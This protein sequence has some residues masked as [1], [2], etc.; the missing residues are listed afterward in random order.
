MS[1]VF[2]ARELALGRDVVV[3]V[4]PPDMAAGVSVDRFRREIQLAAQLQHPHIVPVLTPGASETLPVLHD[5][6]RRRRVASAPA[7]ARGPFADERSARFCATSS[8]RWRTRTTRRRASR[9]QAGERSAVE[10]TRVVRLRYRARGRSRDRRRRT[11]DRDRP[12]ARHTGVHVARQAAG[13]R[14]VDQRTDVGSLPSLMY[15]M[16][17]GT[18]PF[19]ALS[20]REL[21][22]AHLTKEPAPLVPAI[23]LSARSDLTGDAVSRER[24]GTATAVRS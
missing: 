13:D 14:N 21:A 9:H 6:V 1:R 3:K 20:M 10:R 2:V 24:S 19:T 7:R 23:Q 16:L 15:E 4:L 8:M 22:V 18:T 17:S 12:R 11:H 5:A